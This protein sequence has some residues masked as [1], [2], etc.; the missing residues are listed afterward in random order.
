MEE[1]ARRQGD[2]QEFNKQCRMETTTHIQQMMANAAMKK[3][4]IPLSELTENRIA[5]YTKRI[6]ILKGVQEKE[7]KD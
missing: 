2:E 5:M 3:R 6:K 1:K 4:V 7:G